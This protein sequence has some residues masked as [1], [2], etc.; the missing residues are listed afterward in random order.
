[1]ANLRDSIKSVIE[2]YLQ[3]W[4]KESSFDS[5]LNDLANIV[6]E[7]I[8]EAPKAIPHNAVCFFRDGDQW[9]CVFG[10]FINLQ[11]SPAGFGAN[12]IDAFQMLDINH[13]R[14]KRVRNELSSPPT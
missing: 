2:N 1:M 12:F 4:D 13:E 3:D 7:T 14:Q 6:M 8:D 11:E 5:Q 10:N 9:C